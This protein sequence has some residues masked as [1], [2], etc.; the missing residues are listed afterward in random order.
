MS[1]CPV[2]CRAP[3]RVPSEWRARRPPAPPRPASLPLPRPVPSLLLSYASSS[4]PARR[5][6]GG[7]GGVHRRRAR[8]QCRRHAPAPALPGSTRL[9]RRARRADGLLTA[10]EVGRATCGGRTER[11]RKGRAL[12]PRTRPGVV[13]AR[14]KR[15]RASC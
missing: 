13:G 2:T 8:R 6:L 11:D 5:H 15:A 10:G 9:A 4:P 7:E 12:S 1:S 14:R 3:A